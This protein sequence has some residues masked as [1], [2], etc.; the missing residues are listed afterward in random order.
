MKQRVVSRV[1]DQILRRVYILFALFVIFATVIVLRVAALQLNRSEWQQEEMK[2]QI[3][4]K[5]LVADRG[6]ILS[7]DGEILAT[8][9]PFYKIALDPTVI[10]TSRWENFRDSL[11]VLSLNMAL[12]FD[13]PDA[14]D[15]LRV[16]NAV[17]EALAKGDRHVYLTRKKLNFKQLEAAKTW[18]ILNRGRVEGGVVIEKFNNERFYPMGDLARITLG[19]LIDDTLAQRGIE[20][21]FDANLKGRDG[22]VLAQKVVGDSWVPVN[23]FGEEASM[24]GL[25]IVTTIDV[26]IQDIVE[27]ALK[28][29]VEK[30][31]AQFGTAILMEVATGEVK[32]IANYPEAY[33]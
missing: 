3:F 33:N 17:R 10:D 5:K 21:S 13:E 16:Y 14:R 11:Y 19:R 25:D 23:G 18:P 8:S 1:S 7:E 32:A 9:L 22:Y 2:E 12:E 26:D 15:T 28:E 24:D 20:F 30:N 29:G 27:Q 31:M 6:N 4:F